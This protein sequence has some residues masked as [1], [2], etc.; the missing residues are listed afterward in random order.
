MGS[1]MTK[2]RTQKIESQIEYDPNEF[3]SDEEALE[4]EVN[5][6]FHLDD[7]MNRFYNY[8][9]WL[10]VCIEVDQTRDFAP[11]LDLMQS[12][13][14]P[15][16]MRPFIRDLFERHGLIKG[17]RKDMRRTPLYRMT[18]SERELI[19]ACQEVEERVK[20]YG[21]SVADAIQQV[22]ENEEMDANTIEN[23]YT[24]RHNPMR[25]L[26]QRLK[27]RHLRS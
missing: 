2:R 7:D 5:L 12:E 4:D 11:L 19:F 1:V 15:K 13:P 17:V 8:K 10:K 18:R 6:L 3:M 16:E 9:A 14:L 22:A 20:G 27:K 26:R 21:M 24:G 23:A 25:K